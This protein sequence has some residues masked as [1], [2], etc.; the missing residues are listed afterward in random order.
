MSLFA[1]THF[2]LPACK[3][4][5]PRARK[6][7]A[8]GKRFKDPLSQLSS[9][10]ATQLGMCAGVLSKLVNYPLL[11]WKIMVQQGLPLSM[12]PSVIYRGLPMACM[13]LGGT[14]AVQVIGSQLSRMPLSD[15]P[16]M[17]YCVDLSPYSSWHITAHDLLGTISRPWHD[18]ASLHSVCDVCLSLAVL[19][20][21]VLSKSDRWRQS[22]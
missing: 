2:A 5:S 14:T 8:S 22:S 13:N 4:S 15:M 7:M 11:S 1:L 21:R 19:C 18:L 17:P 3:P 20:H 16:H 6:T 10:Q 9:S 12:N